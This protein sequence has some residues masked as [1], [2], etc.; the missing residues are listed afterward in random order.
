MYIVPSLNM[1]YWLAAMMKE[2]G[3]IGVLVKNIN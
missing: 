1:Y 3:I 2:F